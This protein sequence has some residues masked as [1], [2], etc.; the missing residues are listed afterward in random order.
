LFLLLAGCSDLFKKREK[1]LAPSQFSL[2]S[3]DQWLDSSQFSLA[4][5]HF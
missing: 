5:S 4:S 1:W 3:S 2:T